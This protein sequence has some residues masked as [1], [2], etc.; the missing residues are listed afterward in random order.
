[1][2]TVMKNHKVILINVMQSIWFEARRPCGNEVLRSVM[3]FM[4]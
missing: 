3:H 4:H 1:M 2:I